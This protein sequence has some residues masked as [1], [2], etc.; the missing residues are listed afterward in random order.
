M[1]P[2]AEVIKHQMQETRSSLTEKLETLEQQVVGTV[3]STTSA[4]TNTVENVTG[5]VQE[6]AA[7]V[8]ESVRE[9]VENVKDSLDIPRQVQRHPWFML[10]GSV[11]L[12]FVGGRLLQSLE[13]RPVSYRGYAP[14]PRPLAEAAHKT[15]EVAS[16]AA[17][18][19]PGW[20]A[21]VAETFAPEI[22][23][24]KRAGIGMALGFVRDKLA[25]SV[26]PQLQ[27]RVNEIMNDVTLKLGGDPLP[28]QSE[29]GP[30]HPPGAV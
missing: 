19:M 23:K 11:F 26:P 24:L 15:A 30:G 5:A 6:T 1:D 16:A 28:P 8:K 25:E 21:A 9:V 7:T 12:G 18:S 2:E 20:V 29:A 17:R 10:G 14:P 3:Q 27:P 13:P 4:V 22:D